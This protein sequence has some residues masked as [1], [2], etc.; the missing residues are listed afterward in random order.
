M[1]VDWLSLRRLYHVCWLAVREGLV[2]ET[3]V[4]CMLI[5]CCWGSGERG[6]VSC[7]LTGCHQGSCEGVICI[8]CADWLSLRRAY[9][10]LI[11]CC[12]G[13]GERDVCIVHADWLLLRVWWRRRVYCVC[14]LAVVEGPMK[15][16]CVLCDWIGCHWG[17][18][19]RDVVYCV[20]WLAVIEMCVSCV[21]IGCRRGSYEG[22]V[23]Y[24]MLLVRSLQW[25]SQ[26]SRMMSVWSWSSCPTLRWL[27]LLPTLTLLCLYLPLSLSLATTTLLSTSG[28]KSAV[29]HVAVLP[30]WIDWISYLSC[31]LQVAVC[32]MTP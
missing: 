13:S 5:G 15:E 14:W 1:R 28:T 24:C 27:T 23:V 2:K 3:C 32:K 31:K 16:T 26:P 4:L 20:C 9:R 19:E 17:S 7:M 18:S 6:C 11:G 30:V 29:C 8:M 25:C 21:L 12:W 10:V 22:C